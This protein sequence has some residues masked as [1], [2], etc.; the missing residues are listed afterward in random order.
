MRSCASSVEPPTCGVRMTL[1]SPCSGD[2]KRSLLDPG[3]TGKTST[4]APRSLPCAQRIGECVEVGDGAA[5]VVDEKGARLHGFD[6]GAPDHALRRRRF[7]HMHAD[8]VALRQELVQGGGRF[9]VAVAKLVGMVVEHHPHAHRLGEIGQLRADVAVTDDAERLAPDLVAVG[10]GLVPLTLM[11]GIGSRNDPAQQKDNLADHQFRHA[12]RVGEWRIEDRN[13]VPPGGVDIHL[14]GA[15]AEAPDRD[16]P[17]GGF[18]NFRGDLRPRA[19]AEQMH[20]LDGFLQLV[21]IERLRQPRHAGI[22]RSRHHIHGAVVDTFQQQHPDLV[23]GE[24]KLRKRLVV[25]HVAAS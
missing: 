24:R 20:A 25:G 5:A 18:D 21:P 14:V 23:L 8:D 4:A 6:L 22:A 3:S 7:R 15:D 13:P 16:Q 11:G 17:V 2:V 9:G 1:S 10:R 19:D 12:P